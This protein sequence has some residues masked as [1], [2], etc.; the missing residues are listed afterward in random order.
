MIKFHGPQIV[1]QKGANS[2]WGDAYERLDMWICSMCV[3]VQ[4]LV[5]YVKLRRWTG[6]VSVFVKSIHAHQLS[7]VTNW[8]QIVLQTLRR[9]LSVYKLWWTP[10]SHC[11]SF[12]LDDSQHAQ[13]ST[14]NIS[15]SCQVSR[16]P[17]LLGGKKKV[18]FF[19][20]TKNKTCF[21]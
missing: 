4:C 6:D 19:A 17:A 16:L 1:S 18:L 11:L 12:E 15:K 7:F 5:K 13:D 3:R 9:C 20:C 21:S 14:G 10:L 2:C 8:M